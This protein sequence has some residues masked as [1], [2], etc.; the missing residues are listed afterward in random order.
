M[1]SEKKKNSMKTF[2]QRLTDSSQKF[3]S[4]FFNDELKIQ[5]EKQKILEQVRLAMS[6]NRFVVLQIQ[7]EIDGTMSFETVSGKLR[8]NN[9]NKNMVLLT[10]DKTNEIKMIPID[11]IKK[12]SFIQTKDSKRILAE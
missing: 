8:Q 10:L 12:I 11:H 6:Q 9:F 7:E 1:D 2:S 3:L 5:Q 4:S